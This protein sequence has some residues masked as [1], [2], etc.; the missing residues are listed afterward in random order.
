MA[1]ILPDVVNQLTPDGK[2]PDKGQL[3]DMIGS[4]VKQFGK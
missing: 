3:E 4:L 2:A 1:A